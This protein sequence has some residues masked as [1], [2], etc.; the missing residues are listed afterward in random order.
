MKAIPAEV[1]PA[2]EKVKEVLKDATVTDVLEEFR[3]WVMSA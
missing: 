3:I 1:S 2:M